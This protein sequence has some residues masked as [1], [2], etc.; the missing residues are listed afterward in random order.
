MNN[1]IIHTQ[2][3]E[4]AFPVTMKPPGRIPP[5]NEPRTLHC[6]TETIESRVMAPGRFSSAAAVFHYF[7]M[8]L[9]SGEDVRLL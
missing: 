6:Q 9:F 7:R 2:P 5:Y 3:I 8:T 4:A 1:L